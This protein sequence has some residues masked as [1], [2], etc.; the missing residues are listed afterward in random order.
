MAKTP[1]VPR[2]EKMLTDNDF[3][4]F[5]N[6]DGK[7]TLSCVEESLMYQGET[8]DEL[9]GNYNRSVRASK[10]APRVAKSESNDE[11]VANG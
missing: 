8:L 2:L 7:W 9:I 4:L 5:I 10:R 1:I 3:V 6:A 11:S